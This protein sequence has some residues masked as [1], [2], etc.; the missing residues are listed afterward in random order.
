MVD[1]NLIIRSL[2]RDASLRINRQ[3]DDGHG[4]V[5]EYME[6][7]LAFHFSGT[8][9]WPYPYTDSKSSQF[10]RSGTSHV[11]S[12]ENLKLSKGL[13]VMVCMSCQ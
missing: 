2:T 11:R 9:L 13:I 5:N 8:V 6:V 7:N 10:K 3:L 1:E 12:S 4:D